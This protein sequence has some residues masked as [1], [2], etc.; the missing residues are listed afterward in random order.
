MVD[1][2]YSFFVDEDKNKKEK[3]HDDTLK[4][5]GKGEIKH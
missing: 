4:A 2:L 3:M 1:L 5:L